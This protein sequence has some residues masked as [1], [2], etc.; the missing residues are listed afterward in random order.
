[1]CGVRTGINNKISIYTHTHTHTHTHTFIQN[2]LLLIHK[3]EFKK[4]VPI[5]STWVDPAIILSEIR[6]RNANIA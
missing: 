5:C 3:K 6:A 2:G 1:M 4:R